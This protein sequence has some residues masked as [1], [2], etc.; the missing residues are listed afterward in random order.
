MAT[1]SVSV[2]EEMKEKM[3]RL[4]E[5]NWSAVARH[6]FEEKLR[7]VDILKKI[8][9]KS[10]LTA[11]DADEISRKISESMARKFKGME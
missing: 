3:S 6:A 8:A 7:E 2:E 10:K 9:S 4:Q 5:I 1:M 11:K